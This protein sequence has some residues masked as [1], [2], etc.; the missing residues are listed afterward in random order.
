MAQAAVRESVAAHLTDN[1]DLQRRAMSVLEEGFAGAA[2]GGF[3]GGIGRGVRAART[4]P[5]VAEQHQL[6]TPADHAAPAR[7]DLLDGDG[8]EMDALVEK[9]M[10]ALTGP[11]G[12]P[13]MEASSTRLVEFGL[14]AV[15]SEAVYRTGD[16]EQHGRVTG[17][18]EADADGPA[19]VV[20]TDGEGIETTIDLPLQPGES[21]AATEQATAQHQTDDFVG[22]VG[23]S[24][25][26]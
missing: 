1:P 22:Q 6:T 9:G 7:P 16:G 10:D 19:S 12:L 18:I 8:G 20:L 5:T 14:P 23:R 2:G 4:R 24:H 21:I 11:A 15:G 26:V 25:P 3:I 13:G 17:F